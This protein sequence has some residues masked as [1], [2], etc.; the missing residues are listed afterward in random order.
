MSPSAPLLLLLAGTASVCAVTLVTGLLT[1]RGITD[2]PPLE[3]LRQE[4]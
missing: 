1:S 4:T 2:S 3:V